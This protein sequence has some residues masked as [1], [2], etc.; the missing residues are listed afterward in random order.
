MT[1]D[2]EPDTENGPPRMGRGRAVVV[3]LLGA[4]ILAAALFVV[5]STL[6]RAEQAKLPSALKQ[7]PP[8]TAFVGFRASIRRRLRALSIR[9]ASKR[10]D[11]GW[12]ITP[13]QDSLSRECDSAIAAVLARV[14]V[15]DT[16]KRQ[17]RQAAAD[18]V[19]AEYERARL[20]VRIF[21][22]SGM[23][24]DLPDEDSLDTELR[25]FISG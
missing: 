20:K 6:R 11:F 24:R 2:Q 12:N 18:S 7:A 8:D 4:A 1:V 22:R 10:K 3:T 15:L 17:H 25:R 23:R 16:V 14:A 9:C 13:S 5:T 19:K 21:T